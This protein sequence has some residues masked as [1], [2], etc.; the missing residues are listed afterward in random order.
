MK[1]VN[2]IVMVSI[3][4]LRIADG[5]SPPR[6]RPPASCS[7]GSPACPTARGLDKGSHLGEQEG[8]NPQ[9]QGNN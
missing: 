3:G 6:V 4:L 8:G 1:K 5:V 2:H 7:L 9:P